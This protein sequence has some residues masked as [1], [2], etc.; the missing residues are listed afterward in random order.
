MSEH[1]SAHPRTP[2]PVLMR[3][4]FR[5]WGKGA[6]HDIEPVVVTGMGLSGVL[7]VSWYPRSGPSTDQQ[8]ADRR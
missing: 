6:W 4:P 8:R 7:S 2:G 5:E 1:S 3:R